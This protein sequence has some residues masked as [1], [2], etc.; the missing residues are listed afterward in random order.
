MREPLLQGCVMI[1]GLNHGCKA[2]RILLGTSKHSVNINFYCYQVGFLKV[3]KNNY[4][5]LL[6]IEKTVVSLW[7]P[8]RILASL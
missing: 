1:K 5:I 3:F 8:S 6:G 7:M 4:M 2:L